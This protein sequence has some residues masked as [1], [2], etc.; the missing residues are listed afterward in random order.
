MTDNLKDLI[1]DFG[2]GRE[3]QT[4]KSQL[5]YEL[6]NEV[7]WGLKDKAYMDIEDFT[8]YLKAVAKRISVINV[9]GRETTR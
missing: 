4:E 2:G 7:L 5:F 8:E 3:K 6:A 9:M 1:D